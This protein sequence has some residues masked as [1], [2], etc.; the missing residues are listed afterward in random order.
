ME[1]LDVDA[2]E[3]RLEFGSLAGFAY[4]N[5]TGVQIGS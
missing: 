1:V 5:I 3:L 2:P 4:L